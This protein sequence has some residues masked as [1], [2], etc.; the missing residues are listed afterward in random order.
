MVIKGK[1]LA[2]LSTR[3]DGSSK[4]KEGHRWGMF[5]SAALAWRISEEN[6]V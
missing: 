1:Y 2:T 4:F 6:F 5:P 3:W